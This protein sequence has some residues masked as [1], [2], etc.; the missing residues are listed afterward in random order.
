M[1]WL[2]RLY[3]ASSLRC[4]SELFGVVAEP[5]VSGLEFLCPAGHVELSI[6]PAW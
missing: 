1:R 5:V 4:S 3:W 2:S 6:T